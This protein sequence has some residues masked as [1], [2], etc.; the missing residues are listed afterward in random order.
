MGMMSFLLPS[1]LSVDTLRELERACVAGGP[2][3]MPWPSDARVQAER[4]IVNRTVEESGTL[5]VPWDV[6]GAGRLMSSTATLMERPAPYSLPV[7]IARGKINQLRC[8]SAD[9]RAG[10]LALPPELAREVLEVTFAFGRA[11]THADS[12]APVG[13][14]LNRAYRAAGD[15][16]GV[17]LDQVFQIRHARQPQLDTALGVRLGSAV[18]EGA[19][20][21]AL[22]ASCNSICLPLAWNV[23]EPAAGAFRWE[24][25]DAQLAWAES[26]GLE[27]TA[28]PLV[29]FSAARLPEWLWSH[30]RDLSALGRF[31]SRY[32][33]AAVRRYRGR[34][35]R[36]QLTAAS[37][38][39]TLLSLGEDELLLLTV[40]MA[41]AARQVDP[42]LEVIVGLAQPWGEYMAVEERNHS[43]FIFA[44]TLIRS[45]L[46]LAALD[47]ELVMGVTPRGSYCRDLLDTSRLLDMYALLGLPLR[48]TLGYPSSSAADPLADPDFRADAGHWRGGFS[49][50]AQADWA[51]DFVTLAV[52][53]PYVQAVHWTHFSDAEPHTFPHTGLVDSA[54]NLKPALAHLRAL[55]ENHLK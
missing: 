8:Q 15:L 46:T 10:G 38:S 43:P 13:E 39:A 30:E 50:A 12:P 21:E 24:A 7:E 52:C 44:D 45:G 41:E 42:A 16:V 20:A 23:S 37:N 22:L 18:P 32:V 11:V 55:R 14:T 17:Y 5:T 40:R 33:E 36:W 35:R 27:V 9:W 28:G 54:G 2:D 29:D 51:R 34:I 26:H 19:A 48:V 53:K 49:A 31:M 6:N 1:G 3:N 47:V 25:H 4:L